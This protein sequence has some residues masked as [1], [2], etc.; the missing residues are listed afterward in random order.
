MRV[1]E[2]GEHGLPLMRDLQPHVIARNLQAAG[3]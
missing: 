2:G 3:L 1:L